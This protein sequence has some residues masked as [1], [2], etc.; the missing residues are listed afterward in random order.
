MYG[1]NDIRVELYLT[2]RQLFSSELIRYYLEKVEKAVYRTELG[3]LGYLKQTLPDELGPIF[4]AV[5]YRAERFKS[6]TFYIDNVSNG[7]LL[8]S[9]IATG[10]TMWVFDKT[11]GEAFKEAWKKTELHAQMVGILS[12]RVDVRAR[13][14][15]SGINSRREP[16]LGPI[17]GHPLDDMDEP[18][19]RRDDVRTFVSNEDGIMV[20]R[21]NISV[22]EGRFPTASEVIE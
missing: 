22:N 13:Q 2:D 11:F 17:D 7:S 14:I 15:A 16:F 5:R 1:S 12:H 20:V 18:E 21:A 19:G 6:R 3:E 9:G 8:L 4:D 10:V